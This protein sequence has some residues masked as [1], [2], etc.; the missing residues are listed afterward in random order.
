MGG[1]AVNFQI[2]QPILLNST[3]QKNQNTQ[4]KKN[5]EPTTHPK[6]TER[7]TYEVAES[8]LQKFTQNSRV[9]ITLKTSVILTVE[10]QHDKKKMKSEYI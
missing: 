9:K 1:G 4:P 10:R 8:L 2:P 5:S 6:P 7:K 3:T